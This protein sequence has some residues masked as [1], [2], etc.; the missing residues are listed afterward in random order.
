MA[1]LL[2]Y[3]YTTSPL[4]QR[5]FLARISLESSSGVLANLQ[6]PILP[7]KVMLTVPGASESSLQGL[8]PLKSRGS[9]GE[10]TIPGAWLLREV[11]K[12]P[13]LSERR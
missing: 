2:N 7:N 9:D 4:S 10:R 13:R 8:P 5:T 3:I 1:T 12:E 6:R 11:M